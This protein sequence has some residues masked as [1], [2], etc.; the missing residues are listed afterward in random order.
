MWCIFQHSILIPKHQNP[1]NIDLQTPEF[2]FKIK[3]LITRQ[4]HCRERWRRATVWWAADPLAA[5]TPPPPPTWLAAFKFCFRLITFGNAGGPTELV[6]V[7][8][9]KTRQN[10]RPSLDKIQTA[11][12]D[13]QY[14]LRNGQRSHPW[15]ESGETVM[16]VIILIH[17]TWCHI[18]N[19]ILWS[20]FQ[21]PW[22]ADC[23]SWSRSTGC[24]TETITGVW[25]NGNDPSTMP[26]LDGTAGNQIETFRSAITQ[27]K[28]TLSARDVHVQLDRRGRARA[29]NIPVVDKIRNETR[30]FNTLQIWSH[31]LKLT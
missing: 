13:T 24:S 23:W 9:R 28:T 10:V 19:L 5:K 31:I 22:V 17:T 29:C 15:L 27:R 12:D 26:V 6:Y 7:C 16:V 2:V 4:R 25:K 30:N 1:P 11:D 14:Q 20:W 21:I 8:A 18:S 3:I